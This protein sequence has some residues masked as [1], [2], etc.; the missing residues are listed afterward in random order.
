MKRKATR[1]VKG[2]CEG[3]SLSGSVWEATNEGLDKEHRWPPIGFPTLRIRV[4]RLETYQTAL[5]LPMGLQTLINCLDQL[6][7][8]SG[9]HTIVICHDCLT[10]C[11]NVELSGNQARSPALL[12]RSDL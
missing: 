3:Q 2:N 1:F 7:E 5:R 11:I 9:Y 8:I 10:G 4:K 12:R 6:V